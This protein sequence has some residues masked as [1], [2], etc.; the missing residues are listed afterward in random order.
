[1]EITL[2]DISKYEQLMTKLLE[3]GVNRLSSIDFGI[4]ETRK[5]RDEARLKAIRAAKEKAAAMAAELG[6]TLGKPAEIS[7]QSGWNAFQATANS[8]GYSN[9]PSFEAEESTVA[10]G[11]VTIRASVRVS[12][13]LE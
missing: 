12:F 7:E 2:M 5:L 11:E 10:P 8:S 3:A 9:N 4:R 1:M 6:Q 13:Q